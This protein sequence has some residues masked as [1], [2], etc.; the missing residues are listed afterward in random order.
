LRWFELRGWAAHG[1]VAPAWLLSHGAWR[2]LRSSPLEYTCTLTRLVRLG[3]SDVGQRPRALR[4]WSQV[5]SA[6]SAWRRGMSVGW[7]DLLA[8]AQRAAPLV[9]IELHP[10][11][12]DHDRLGRLAETL[13]ARALEAQRQPLTMAQAAACLQ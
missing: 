1:F 8:R 3:G 11:D 13:Y 10:A 7:N 12:A 9:R 4:A 6:R 5:F 2:A